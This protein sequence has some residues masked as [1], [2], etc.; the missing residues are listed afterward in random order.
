MSPSITNAPSV[1]ADSAAIPVRIELAI[2]LAKSGL[3]TSRTP[4]P[5]A[6]SPV[7]RQ[8]LAALRKELNAAG[9]SGADLV[10]RLVVGGTRFYERREVR[11]AVAYLRALANPDDEVSLRRILN[12]P[13]RGIGERAEAMVE[14]F[15]QRER[16]GFNAALERAAE[17]AGADALVGFVKGL[18]ATNPGADVT[19]IGHSYGSL[20]TG[21]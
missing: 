8:Q 9:L 5:A 13:K 3:W 6:A 19:V 17:D 4:A 1:S 16:I 18:R 14:A 15:G 12:T 10:I 7:T 20:V 11:D 2:P 21:A